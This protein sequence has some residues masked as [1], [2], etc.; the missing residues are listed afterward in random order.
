MRH[1]DFSERHGLLGGMKLF[2][3]ASLAIA[4][5]LC[6]GFATPLAA[7]AQMPGPD[8]STLTL[9]GS[10]TVPFTLSGNHIYVTAQIDGS[11]YAFIFDT[12]GAATLAADLEARLKP[13]VIGHA[14]IGGA[15]DALAPVDI[16][17]VQKTTLGGV[18]YLNGRFVTLPAGFPGDSPIRGVRY[19]GILGRELFAHLVTSIDYE[20]STLTFTEP[21]HFFPDPGASVIPVVMRHGIPHI[22]ASVN[23]HPGIFAVDAGSAQALT[24][25]QSFVDDSGLAK[26]FNSSIDVEIGRGIGGYLTG[27]ASRARTLEIGS[28]S[29]KNPLSMVVHA[30]GGIFSDKT[31]GGNIGGDILRQFT[32]T[33]DAPHGK[34]YLRPNASFGQPMVFNRAGMFSRSENGMLRVVRVIPDSPAAV[35]GVQI[36]DV[37]AA[38]NGTPASRFSLEETRAI[39]LQQPGTRIA[40]D[41]TRGGK[42][43]SV[44]F[45]L[46]DIL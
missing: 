35:A 15:G 42:Y 10:T 44:T 4:C 9:S 3:R 18:T 33:L 39:W 45:L 1:R 46:R 5:I 41:L 8:T 6:V 37:V 43:M 36:G 24:L 11:P 23:G 7:G 38:I 20:K 26:E 14:L 13:E 25:T 31:L 34:L 40:L 16:V 29:L 32:V 2:R 30:K 22:T 17:R 12:G 27:T 21:A 28:I 19:G